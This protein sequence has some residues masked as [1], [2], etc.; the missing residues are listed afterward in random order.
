MGGGGITQDIDCL[1]YNADS[2]LGEGRG[3]V[4]VKPSSRGGMINPSIF[5]VMSRAILA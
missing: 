2:T 3:G 1:F 4:I 5:G